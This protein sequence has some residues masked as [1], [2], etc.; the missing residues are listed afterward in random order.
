VCKKIDA[1][2]LSLDEYSKFFEVLQNFNIFIPQFLAEPPSN[3]LQNP[4][5]E[6]LH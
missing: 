4:G 2:F 6:T 5:P 3:G 1:F